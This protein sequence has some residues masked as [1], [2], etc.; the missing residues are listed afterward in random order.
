[1][2]RYRYSQFFYKKYVFVLDEIGL[3][4][5]P[6]EP[7]DGADGGDAESDADS[8]E[9]IDAENDTEDEFAQIPDSPKEREGKADEEDA[10]PSWDRDAQAEGRDEDGKTMR[11]RGV[12]CRHNH[13]SSSQ[14]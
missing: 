1:L 7:T 2:F 5:T 13:A 10:T 4:V 14:T 6:D 8:D 3:N 12:R 9:D 11:R